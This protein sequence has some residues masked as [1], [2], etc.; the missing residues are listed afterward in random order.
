[1]ASVDLAAVNEELKKAR[2]AHVDA[3]VKQ[4][5][6]EFSKKMAFEAARNAA[7]ARSTDGKP[8][9]EA[10]CERAAKTDTDYLK[11]CAAELKATAAILQAD[12]QV[13]YLR[14]KFDMYLAVVNQK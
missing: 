10:A 13:E 3:V 8:P 14:R 9:S 12:V 2:E 6:A 4:L 7:A 1:M 5:E 11:L